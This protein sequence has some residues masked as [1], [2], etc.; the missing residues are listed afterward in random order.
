MHPWEQR[1]E[2]LRTKNHIAGMSV[3]ITDKNKIIYTKGF[4]VESIER[5]EVSTR[6][7]TLYAVASV[8]K[9]VTGILIM[10]LVE[11]GM[12][13]LDIP[14][15]EYIPW[16]TLNPPKATEQLTLRHLLNH[17]GGFPRG[18]GSTHTNVCDE[19]ALERVLREELSNLELIS[20]PEDGKYQ[21]S[22]L[23]IRIAGLIAE[24]V[25]GKRYSELAKEL[26]LEPLGMDHSTFDLRVACTYPLSLPHVPSE[27]G[28]LKVRHYIRRD[29]THHASGG[30]YSN[31][32]DLCKLARLL[33]NEG[34]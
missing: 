29:A 15:K 21:Y 4:G 33:L 17:T 19:L 25:T 31:P 3:A 20:L 1:I 34:K 26:V 10:R 11:Q 27:S 6:P 24:G 9:M 7:D 23:G 28:A 2:E 5:P 16:L 32:I 18:V 8:T 14:V 12:L 22:N 13:H 30:L